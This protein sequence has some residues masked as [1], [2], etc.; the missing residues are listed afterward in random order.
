MHSP[1]EAEPGEMDVFAYFADY[2]NDEPELHK[3]ES[4]TVKQ[5]ETEMLARN[6][7]SL[8]GA[9]LQDLATLKSSDVMGGMH[10]MQR[11]ASDVKQLTQEHTANARKAES[12]FADKL[13]RLARITFVN[14]LEA[15]MAGSEERHREKMTRMQVKHD[16]ALVKARDGAQ[17]ELRRALRI[18]KDNLT[19]QHDREMAR[20]KAGLEQERNTAVEG[21]K[22]LKVNFAT[23][24]VEAAT[25]KQQIEVLRWEHKA[26]KETQFKYERAKEDNEDLRQQLAKAEAQVNEA[27]K[28]RLMQE[29]MQEAGSSRPSSHGSQGLHRM[30]STDQAR[31]IYSSLTD[32]KRW[33]YLDGS[34]DGSGDDPVGLASRS[35]STGSASRS[36][37]LSFGEQ[38]VRMQEAGATP[39]AGLAGPSP[40]TSMNVAQHG[41]DPS[42]PGRPNSRFGAQAT[43]E[44]DAGR[45]KNPEDGPKA[46]SRPGSRGTAV[47]KSAEFAP[48]SKPPRIARLTSEDA[49][50]LSRY[51]PPAKARVGGLQTR[52][53]NSFKLDDGQAQMVTVP[54]PQPRVSEPGRY[55]RQTSSKRYDPPDSQPMGGQSV[56]SRMQSSKRQ[57]PPDSQP[58]N[59]QSVASRMQQR[60]GKSV[61]AANRPPSYTGLDKQDSLVRGP[62]SVAVPADP[63]KSLLASIQKLVA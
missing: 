10:I 32:S 13:H 15:A 35:G 49:G 56:A 7:Q 23:L 31:A 8:H 55:V 19:K 34:A 26:H 42:S 28:A 51:A 38:I 53:S 44:Q 39:G 9:A 5:E 50:A 24:A 3:V 63:H 59:S 61:L 1:E 21:F 60:T 46:G 18:Q 14:G 29:V 6:L 12:S 36:G 17:T 27:F 30:D 41:Y 22:T 43:P 4:A 54:S 62:A 20:L 37:S 40:W 45:Q 52:P 33:S 25:A 2:D 16:H 11:Y 47:S 58:I 48:R 57:D